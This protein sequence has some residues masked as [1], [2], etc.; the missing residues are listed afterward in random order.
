MNKKFYHALVS[1][2]FA[3]LFLGVI[4]IVFASFEGQYFDDKKLFFS[5]PTEN[6]I[7][8]KLLVGDY[9]VFSTVTKLGENYE[10]SLWRYLVGIDSL[11][12]FYNLKLDQRKQL[13][14]VDKFSAESV[15]VHLENQHALV[16]LNGDIIGPAE[17]QRALISPDRNWL[18][19][20]DF[21]PLG[22][23]T[24]YLKNIIDNQ[25]IVVLTNGAENLNPNKDN[26]KALAWSDDSKILYVQDNKKVYQF[27][28]QI[29]DISEVTSLTDLNTD[30]FFL[31]PQ[32]NIIMAITK[33]NGVSS[34]YLVDIESN[35][36]LFVLANS[37]EDIISAYYNQAEDKITYNLNTNQP[38]V[39]QVDVSHP[40]VVSQKFLLAGK[41][42]SWP[43]ADKFI[44]QQGQDI[45]LYSQKENNTQLIFSASSTQDL[46]EINFLDMF[47]IH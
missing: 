18:A 40:Q 47:K 9:A 26:F 36:S 23:A 28:P 25:S 37:A 29:L 7:S 39:W 5:P 11:V 15:S 33:V 45:Y 1:L 38:Q 46:V 6:K 43:E 19:Y 44:I 27:F 35:K 21:S 22:Q 30:K 17:N 2:L 32:E 14:V 13:P 4:Y 34:L 16:H 8:Q 10:F 41:L 20:S 31:Q 24:I 42:L 3:L 12:K